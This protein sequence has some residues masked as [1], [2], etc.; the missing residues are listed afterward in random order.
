MRRVFSILCGFVLPM[1]SVVAVLAYGQSSIPAPARN[2]VM[3]YIFSE[4][5]LALAIG[6]MGGGMLE[7]F[8][9]VN[10]H[11]EVS[12]LAPPKGISGIVSRMAFCASTALMWLP[13]AFAVFNYH[14]NIPMSIG[15]ASIFAA[16]MPQI[17][18]GVL[19]R[20]A[21]KAEDELDHRVT[22]DPET[23]P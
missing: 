19:R 17:A 16:I 14:P 11:Q 20:F 2:S 4:E 15:I 6:A 5:S 13:M 18:P 9:A 1:S 12:F 10:Y 22:R 7:L 21:S 23:R 3:Q 8:I